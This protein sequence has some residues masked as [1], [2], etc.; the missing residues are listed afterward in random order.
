MAE[1]AAISLIVGK[2]VFA[3]MGLAVGVQ[4]VR[5]GRRDGG[6]GV[7]GIAVAAI[8]VGGLGLVTIPIGEAMR[9]EP[10]G[11][12]LNIFGEVVMRVG[13]ALLVVFIWR[14]FRPSGALGIFLLVLS[15]S[16]L[17]GSITWDL[18]A[19]PRSQAYDD[20]LPSAYAN[21]LG[22]AVQFLWATLESFNHWLQSR[23][24]LALG[25]VEAVVCNR[26]LLWTIACGAFVGVGVFACFAG[27]ARG[28]GNETLAALFTMTRS[29]LY[30]TKTAAIALGYFWP[31]SLGARA[32]ES[33]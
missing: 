5:Q 27:A 19:Q 7:Q 18:I 22:I 6:F 9:S 13:M 3:A 11:P 30:V 23:K 20:S 16:V 8:L 26:F 32:Q 28:A 2:I 17:A 21:Q 14:V 4:L 31:D 1:I 12:P 25:L 10:F 33:H 15:L 29:F 24:R